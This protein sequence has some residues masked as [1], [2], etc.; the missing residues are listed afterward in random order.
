MPHADQIATLVGLD[1]T[2]DWKP[3][4]AN[5]FNRVTKGRILEAVREAK[6]EDTARLLEGLKKSEMAREAER[7]M[8]DSG[9]LPELLR[10]PGLT[11]EVPS[12]PAEAADPEGNQA[13]EGDALPKFLVAGAAEAEGE[14]EPLP[15]FLDGEDGPG[16]GDHDMGYAIAAE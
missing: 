6:G 11:A 10:T 4:A 16:D 9:W 3:T 1:M 2:R 7:L 5:Y 13:V 14:A 15:S 8:A 12:E